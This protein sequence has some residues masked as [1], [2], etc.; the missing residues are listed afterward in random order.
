M[1]SAGRWPGVFPDSLRTAIT[2]LCSGNR[3][4]L[5]SEKPPRCPPM[6]SAADSQLTNAGKSCHLHRCAVPRARLLLPL[7]PDSF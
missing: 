1:R 2:A 5:V 6:A 3:Q 7:I 4:R